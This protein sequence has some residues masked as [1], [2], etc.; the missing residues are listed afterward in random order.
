MSYLKKALSADE[1]VIHAAKLHW[2]VFAG[3]AFLVVLGFL[4]GG[5]SQGLSLLLSVLGVIS[6]VGVFIERSTTDL[7][8]TNKKVLAKTGL[9]AR[10]TVEQRLGKIDSVQ[11][12]Q[13]VL[14]RILNFGSVTVTG[15]G[16]VATPIKNVAD[17][18]TFRRAVEQAEEGMEKA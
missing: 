3:P 6:F 4:F 11:V 1:R 10:K 5:A 15:S 7:A 2:I 12:Q 16:F 13:D 9:I 8:V 18:M 17:P 14:G